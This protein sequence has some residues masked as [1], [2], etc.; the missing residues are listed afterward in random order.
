RAALHRAPVVGS[1][2]YDAL[3]AIKK[4]LKDV[5]SPQGMFEDLGLKD[6]GPVDGHAVG[7][8]EAALRRA[9]AFGGPVIVHAVT[10]KG[11]GY[12]PAE[13]DQVDAWHSNNAIEHASERSN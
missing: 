11:F 2:L 13:T 5:L 1:A 8:V 6:R 7:A 10:T 9:R 3:H 4:G 12:P